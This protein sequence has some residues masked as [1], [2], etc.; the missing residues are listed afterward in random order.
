MLVWFLWPSILVWDGFCCSAPIE[1][2]T[3]PWDSQAVASLS[4]AS[5]VREVWG[6]ASVAWGSVLFGANQ[7]QS[8]GSAQKAPKSAVIPFHLLLS[9]AS[10]NK[11]VKW[12]W[13]WTSLKASMWRERE[14]DCVYA[15][16]H[17]FYSLGLSSLEFF[18]QVPCRGPEQL[19]SK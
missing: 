10:K 15:F 11:R 4:S 16:H 8:A 18:A 9:A 1:E 12:L 7:N 13:C 14:R 2:G 19:P 17:I 6:L 5:H 3:Y